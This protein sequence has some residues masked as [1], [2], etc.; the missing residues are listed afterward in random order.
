MPGGQ[1]QEDDVTGDFGGRSN[2]SVPRVR[3]RTFNGNPEE[4]KEWRREV[5][6]STLLY[7]VAPKQMAGL[8]YLALAPGA[9]KPRD[10]L[11]HMDIQSIMEE[12]GLN[13]V[14]KILDKEYV[15]ESYVKA[16]EAQARYERCRRTPG[17]TMEDYLRE[18]RVAK[19]LLEREDPGTTISDVSF[20]RK[21]LRR[22]GLTAL[23]QRGVLAAVGASWETPRR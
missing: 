14:L 17:Q 10:L 6:A 21:L 19:R 15:R 7:N 4:Y 11:S 20:A 23:E 16:D 5:Q 2:G 9:G 22:S 13:T 8:V 3:L 18:A 1:E 12:D